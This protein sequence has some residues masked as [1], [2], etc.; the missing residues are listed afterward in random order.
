MKSMIF[1][2][3]LGTRLRPI[4]DRI[5]KALLPVAGKPLLQW[6]IEK[7]CA[8]GISDI[9]INVHHFPQQIRQ[10]L[11]D[12][13]NFGCNIQLSDESNQL[14]ETGGGL[15]KAA[16]LLGYQ[17]PI[18]ALNVDILSTVNLHRLIAA[19]TPDSMATLVVSDRQ[20]ERYLL[21]NNQNELTGWTNISTGAYKPVEREA[22]LSDGLQRGSL[23]K[24]AFSGMHIIS[25]EL[26]KLMQNWGDCFPIIDFYLSICT[27]YPVHAYVPQDYR[28][29]DI[30]KIDHL[31][32]AENF[33]LKLKELN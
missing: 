14:L 27:K 20:T 17:E 13:D 5:P 18:L 2:A 31:D 24:M 21:F 8:A 6:Q 23:H 33:A 29:M 26:F 15:R 32:E 7:L 30:G 25:P 11:I 4:T 12:H 9:V 22:E 3:G 16:T 28:M 1:A 10:F 19:H